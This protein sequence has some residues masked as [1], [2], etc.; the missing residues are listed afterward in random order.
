MRRN[1][2]SAICG[3]VFVAVPTARRVPAIE[4]SGLS[5]VLA[6]GRRKGKSADWR[7]RK[8]VRMF[9]QPARLGAAARENREPSAHR[10]VEPECPLNQRAQL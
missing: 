10:F 9:K 1:R 4:N 6:R 7:T 2:T 5:G 8:R 3:S